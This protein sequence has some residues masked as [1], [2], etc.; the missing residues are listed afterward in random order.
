MKEIKEPNAGFWWTLQRLNNRK[1]IVEVIDKQG[2]KHVIT[3]GSEKRIGLSTYRK[4]YAFVKPVADMPDEKG[5]SPPITE[6]MI[7]KGGRNQGPSQIVNRPPAP[8]PIPDPF[9]HIPVRNIPPTT[10]RF[11][12]KRRR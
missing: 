12:G 11:T 8:A 10:L 7:V 9:A 1:H 4:D 3:L 6:G 2:K 5:S